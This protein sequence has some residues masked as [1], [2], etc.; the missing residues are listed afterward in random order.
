MGDWGIG[1]L[2]SDDA[3]EVIA[4]VRESEAPQAKLE[5]LL[6]AFL[7][8]TKR[9][10]DE[11]RWAGEWKGARE[12]LALCQLVRIGRQVDVASQGVP[13]TLR[14]WLKVSSF[15]STPTSVALATAAC[16]VLN[17]QGLRARERRG[18]MSKVEVE[19]DALRR[20]LE[21]PADDPLVI[22]TVA[23]GHPETTE[24]RTY[25]IDKARG[26]SVLLEPASHLGAAKRVTAMHFYREGV[27]GYSEYTGAF[28]AQVLF[29]DTESEVRRKMGEPTASGGGS[30]SV[31]VLNK[32]IPRWLRYDKERM[33]RHSAPS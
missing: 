9:G 32:R 1:V 4:D 5:Q 22:S 15:R 24:D 17:M 28:P 26:F 3:L 11:S 10:Y 16:R 20:L 29:R 7:D 30:G 21:R 18:S 25:V 19:F 2:Q 13:P 33:V 6:L 14:E 27:S 31:P 23:G 12:V 8:N